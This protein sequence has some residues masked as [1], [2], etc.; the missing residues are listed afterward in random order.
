MTTIEAK[1]FLIS[2]YNE[3][4]NLTFS[5]EWKKEKQIVK[6]DIICRVFT[7]KNIGTVYIEEKNGMFSILPEKDISFLTIDDDELKLLLQNPNELISAI[8]NG[9]NIDYT[10]SSGQSLLSYCIENCNEQLIKSAHILIECEVNL[11]FSHLISYKN[12]IFISLQ[13]KQPL[14][15]FVLPILKNENFNIL[16]DSYGES[17]LSLI[18]SAI[19]RFDA[20]KVEDFNLI[21]ELL[22][23]QG[24]EKNILK[25]FET[26]YGYS[27]NYLINFYKKN[28][29]EINPEHPHLIHLIR[30]EKLISATKY[31][32]QLNVNPSLIKIDGQSISSYFVNINN[33]LINSIEN[34]K[35]NS[36][37]GGFSFMANYDIEGEVETDNTKR[38]YAIQS[39]LSDV[40][41]HEPKKQSN[42]PLLKK[43]KF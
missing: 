40:K 25:E 32:T 36:F 22:I 18:Y 28:P 14:D 34:L 42:S 8:K 17:N 21:T 15:I 6:N 20:Y 43:K 41:K 12:P 9:L 5:T 38:F 31:Y 27:T 7:H 13:K 29:N 35:F 1:N 26:Q 33:E 19:N 11:D 10:F 39:F 3:E 23:E 24:Y 4:N 37:S 16:N 2:H 30:N